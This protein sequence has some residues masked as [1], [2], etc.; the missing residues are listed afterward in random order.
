M[1]NA[2]EEQQFFGKG[3]LEDDGD[4]ETH[5]LRKPHP[6]GTTDTA[7]RGGP[8]NKRLR[9]AGYDPDVAEEDVGHEPATEANPV[10]RRTI[11]RQDPVGARRTSSS[12]TQRE[13]EEKPVVCAGQ[14]SRFTFSG[15]RRLTNR[16]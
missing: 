8:P 9:T 6:Q 2:W 11:G 4:F 16:D 14:L 10:L 13:A 12:P 3:D 15:R 5:S 1:S 7:T